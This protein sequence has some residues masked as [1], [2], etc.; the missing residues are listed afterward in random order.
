MAYTKQQSAADD[1][2]AG[3]HWYC[4][5]GQ[6]Q[7]HVTSA[8]ALVPYRTDLLLDH[9][10]EMTIHDIIQIVMI[11]QHCITAASS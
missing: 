3:G 10:I 6:K 4:T 7:Q 9:D 2:A 8:A 11:L 5:Y 1:V